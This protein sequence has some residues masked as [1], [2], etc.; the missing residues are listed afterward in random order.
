MAQKKD[1]KATGNIGFEDQLWNAACIL[2][3]SMNAENYKNITLGLVFLKYIS[4]RFDERHKEL[5]AE[6]EG[7]EEDKDEYTSKS[8]FYVPQKAR[9]NYILQYAS[10]PEIGRVIDDAMVEIEKEYPKQLQGVLPKDYAKPDWDKIKLGQVIE[11]FSNIMMMAADNDRDVLGRTYEYFLTKFSTQAG[12]GG[13][14]FTPPC[15]VRILV[16]TIKPF[17]GKVYDPCCGSGGMFVQSAK[18]INEHSG[19]VLHD[20]TIYGQDANPETWRL[21][22]MNLAIRG[23][24]SDLGSKADDTFAH[25]Q[26]PLLKADYILANPPFNLS[27]WGANALAT[28]ARWKYGVPS[29]S[30]ANFAWIQHMLS[31]LSVNGRIGMVLA[32]G[33][34]TSNSN[35]EGVIRKNI[36]EADLVEGIVSLPA[37]LFYTV[38]I[39]VCLWFFSKSKQQSKKTLFIDARNLGYMVTRTQK[40]F[41]EEE[42]LRIANTFDDFRT[43]KEVDSLGFS[44]V[45]TID[46]IAKQ[47]YMLTPGRYVGTE[48]K[49]DD[50]EPFEEKMTRLTSE[51]SGL[52]EESHKLEEEIKKQLGAIGYEI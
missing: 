30:N 48:E 40:E 33:S 20:V 45:C 14:F 32:N 49:E 2:W 29:D 37:Q 41:T 15:I 36:V 47:D 8:I 22:K 6:G 13:E 31:H 18:F 25:D 21:C 23:I 3:G 51:L 39:P 44:K 26:H 17:H 1:N 4:E 52:F 10:K 5:V 27:K 46:E 9:W 34:L 16:N 11:E 19:N 43:G 38:Q 28:D 50:G 24:S 42:I 12:K 7:F 35:N